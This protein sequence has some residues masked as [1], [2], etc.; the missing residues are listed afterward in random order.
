MD[1]SL[2]TTT[3]VRGNLSEYEIGEMF[4]TVSLFKTPNMEKW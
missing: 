4:K 3:T 2:A 1:I